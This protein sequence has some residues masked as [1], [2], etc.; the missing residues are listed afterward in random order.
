MLPFAPL[1]ILGLACLA[2]LVAGLLFLRAFA[3]LALLAVLALGVLLALTAVLL[4][5]LLLLAVLFRAPLLA[6]LLIAV[7]LLQM[8]ENLFVCIAVVGHALVG[9]LGRRLPALLPRS[10]FAAFAG[11][12]LLVA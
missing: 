4:A 9:L 6:V 3:C 1:L 10:L 8:L 12:A 11:S 2:T 7:L 5:L